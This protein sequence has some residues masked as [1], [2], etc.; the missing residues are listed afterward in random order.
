MNEVGKIYYEL[1]FNK[2][3]LNIYFTLLMSDSRMY[4]AV[5]WSQKNLKFKIK[6]N[7]FVLRMFQNDHGYYRKL[8]EGLR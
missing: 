7:I 1:L 6:Q 3:L 4:E 5:L 2:Y 8:T